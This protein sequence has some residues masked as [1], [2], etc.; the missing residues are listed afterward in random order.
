MAVLYCL[1]FNK[2]AIFL[3]DVCVK[4]LMFPSLAFWIILRSSVTKDIQ[5]LFIFL[6]IIQQKDRTM[7]PD[8]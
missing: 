3:N 4:V 6:L 2:M 7:I 5:L 8:V 1:N